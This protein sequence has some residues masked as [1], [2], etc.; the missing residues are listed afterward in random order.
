MD[1]DMELDTDLMA[2]F[3]S[4][5]TTDR[6]VLIGEFQK[7]A[8]N[9]LNPTACAFFLDMNNWNLQAAI[10]SYYD[11]ENSAPQTKLPRMTLIKDVTI[12]EG[13]SIT[14]DTEFTKTWRVKNNGEEPWPP[15]ISLRFTS[16]HQLGPHDHIFLE[17]L[18]PQQ[19][20][21]I[22]IRM[23]SP[24]KCGLYQGQWRMCTTTGFFFG[25]TI[26]VIL[27]VRT[28]GMLGLTQQMSSLAT[29]H[30]DIPHNSMPLPFGGHPSSPGRPSDSTTSLQLRPPQFQV[31]HFDSSSPSQCISSPAIFTSV[32]HQHYT[33]QQY[34]MEQPLSSAYQQM[35][36]TEDSQSQESSSPRQPNGLSHPGSL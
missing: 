11:I 10:G 7:L 30:T 20:L 13:E 29:D 16:G 35:S 18:E 25:E 4:L 15:G 17:N 19:T 24:S 12:G 3:S 6:D 8:G 22:S 2:K 5:G 14:P 23:K 34:S 28:D 9:N 26:W 31:N 21:D 27:D 32:P 33:S 36:L 1:V